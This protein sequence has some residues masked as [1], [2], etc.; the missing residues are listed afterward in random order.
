MVVLGLLAG[1]LVG[2]SANCPRTVRPLTPNAGSA[3]QGRRQPRRRVGRLELAD[4]DIVHH[5]IVPVS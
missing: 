4:G 5:E 1:N 2:E 3:V